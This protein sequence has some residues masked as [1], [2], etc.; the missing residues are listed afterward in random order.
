MAEDRVQRRLAA[1]VAMDI[2]GYSRLMESDEEGTLARMKSQRAEIVDPGLDAYR[3]R[4][5]KTTGDGLL[6]E[7]ASA[8]DA[9]AY[10]VAVQTQIAEAESRL[11][12]ADRMLMRVGVNLGDIVVDGDDLFGGGVNVAARLQQLA[13]PGGICIS[14][15]LVKSIRGRLDIDLAD[16]GEHELKNMDDPVRV[17][18]WQPDG[19]VSADAAGK[20]AAARKSTKP[21][22][23]VLPFGDL[24][25][26]GA[27]GA[28]CDALTED[29]IA[30]LAR[31]VGVM[32]MGRGT[33]FSYKDKSVGLREI[34]DDLGVAYV[35]EGSV[36]QIGDAVAINAQLGE[37]DSGGQVWAE[38][39]EGSRDDIFSLQN[40]ITRRIVAALQPALI[41]ELADAGGAPDSV[42]A[43]VEIARARKAFW[44]WEKSSM[45]RAVTHVRRAIAIEPAYAEAH[46]MLSLI[47]WGEAISGFTPQPSEAMSEALSEAQAALSLNDTSAIGH[48]AMAIA[49][50]SAGDHGAAIAEAERAVELQPGQ[51]D[52]LVLAAYPLV[53]GG[54]ESRALVWAQESLELNPR[55][56]QVY[57]RHQLIATAHFALEHYEDALESAMAVARLQ[58]DWL[59]GRTFSIA[60]LEKLGR[61][62]EAREQYRLAQQKNPIYSVDYA[63]RRHPFRS[64]EIAGRLRGALESAAT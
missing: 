58:P 8:V 6:A 1:I 19:S 3:G 37:T 10:A 41:H 44:R 51:S 56:P 61:H 54:A 53:Y 17:W 33:T 29:L 62:E 31:L 52:I 4:L 60:S 39:F 16:G 35:L 2:V 43:W 50:L 27:N 20:P 18:L 21:S 22:I 47:R 13:G 57:G 24:S 46:A 28:F 34:R 12:P 63:L 55:D 25:Q 11:P 40:R 38:A 9:V 26:D 48:A 5:F 42:D 23:L 30:D 49:L 59:E 7:F 14:D 36:R 64:A 32:V 15:A 45:A